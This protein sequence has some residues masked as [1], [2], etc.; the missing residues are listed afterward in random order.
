V[1][2]LLDPVRRKRVAWTPEEEVRQGLL[3]Y[4]LDAVGVPLHALRVELSLSVFDPAVKDRVDVVAWHRE[5]PILLCECKAPS[6]E[7]SP[8]VSAQLRRYLRLVPSPW[9]LETNGTAFRL[10]RLVDGAWQECGGFPRWE[11]MVAQPGA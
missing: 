7:L 11:E 8:G 2:T 3:R 9:V 4:L 5:R 1:K 6:V 10:H